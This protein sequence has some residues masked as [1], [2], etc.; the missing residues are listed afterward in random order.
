MRGRLA[1]DIT[2]GLTAGIN[3][4]YDEAFDTRVSAD[5]KVR[6]GGAA[7]TA[8]RKEVQQLPVINALTSTPINRDARV[9]DNFW[10]VLEKI[11]AAIP[12]K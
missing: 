5:L 10:S 4:S 2:Q 12:F 6:F 1:Y 9:H 11:Y 8:Q 3:V 7:T